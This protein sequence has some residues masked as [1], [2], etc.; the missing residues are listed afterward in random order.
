M[1]I[2]EILEGNLEELSV[3]SYDNV[4]NLTKRYFPSLDS[5]GTF[6]IMIYG[7]CDGSREGGQAF[8]EFE[9]DKSL[10]KDV[11]VDDGYDFIESVKSSNLI[12]AVELIAKSRSG[13]KDPY[14]N[15]TILI[16]SYNDNRNIIEDLKTID[17]LFTEYLNDP[18]RDNV[19]LLK[20][21]LI[22]SVSHSLVSN[23]K[24]TVL[25]TFLT[26]LGLG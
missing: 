18:D 1:I 9:I 16:E 8:L 6:E 4:I 15:E 26:N 22:Y 24:T 14:V 11:I 17:T 3:L 23:F 13:D 7:Y 19:T 2:K 10:T 20:L 25:D 21:S 12:R 5:E